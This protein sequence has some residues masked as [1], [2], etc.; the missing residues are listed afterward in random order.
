MYSSVPAPLAA[1]PHQ[2]RALGGNEK[3]FWRLNESGSLNC[4]VL[5]HLGPGSTLVPERVRAALAALQA[6]HPLLRAHIEVRAGQPWFVWPQAVPVLTLETRSV[7]RDVWKH[8]IENELRRVIPWTQAPL[9]RALLLE[10]GSEGATMALFFH[11]SIADGKAVIAALRDVLWHAVT[12]SAQSTVVHQR[13]LPS[14]SALPTRSRG[15]FGGLRRLRLVAGL[16]AD[17]LRERERDPVKVPVKQVAAPHE[18]TY[19]VEPRGFDAKLSA[20]LAARARSV[21]STVHGAIGAA[22][23][24]GV[25]RAAGVRSERVVTFGSPINVRERLSPPMGEQMGL[26]LG[27]SHFRGTIAPGTRFWTLARAIRERIAED[28]DSGRAVDALPLI[29]LFYQSLGGDKATAIDF[30]RKWA[31]ANGTTGLTNLGRI[32]VEP[33]PGLTIERVRCLGFPSGL[34]VFN[35]LASSYAGSLMLDFNWPEPCFD[36]AS[37]LALVDDIVGTLRAAVHGEPSFAS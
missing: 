29:H 19:H 37:A 1:P 31:E 12:G 8:V 16:A 28:V 26:Y 22:M 23:L 36:R 5:A 35:A 25:A 14:E 7:A 27:A 15:V 17:G 34:D 21:G 13:S 33:P 20:A 3:A 32:D 10:H 2:A 24:F 11:H 4:A 30:G 18:R 9:G 6:R